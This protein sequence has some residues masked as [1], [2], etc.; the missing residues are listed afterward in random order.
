MTTSFRDI[1]RKARRALHK[2]LRVPAYYLLPTTAGSSD[3][4]EKPVLVYVR[5][6]PEYES[7]GEIPGRGDNYAERQAVTPRII[8]MR[9]E[10]DKPKRN[11]VISIEDGEAY[12]V[13][14]T[15][16]PNDI[17][18]TAE[19]NRMREADL[20]GLPFPDA[21]AALNWQTAPI[22]QYPVLTVNDGE[23][24]RVD[25]NS[26]VDIDISAAFGAETSGKEYLDVT[27]TGIDAAWSFAADSGE[28]NA[29]TGEWTLSGSINTGVT[30]T[31][32]FTPPAD[33]D[34]DL[35][36]MTLAATA[37]EPASRTTASTSQ[38]FSVTV[39]AEV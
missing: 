8:F 29:D 33:S 9:E 28:Y 27:L 12:R 3:K 22:A 1:K 14:N 25:E 4:Y 7:L 35:T 16:P 39:D 21:D 34:A 38:P 10:V 26:S 13:D 37:Y 19:V 23:E 36:G 5:Y 31:L 32:S 2:E 20:D 17:T 15:L 18:I 6:H 11:A 30:A 24:V